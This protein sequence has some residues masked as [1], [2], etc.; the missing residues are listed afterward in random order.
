MSS[1]NHDDFYKNSIKK[2]SEETRTVRKIVSIVLLV[3]TISLVVAGY[4]G[5]SYVKNGLQPVDPNSKETKTI[6]IPIGSSVSK[7]GDILEQ[8]GII[9]NSRLFQ[10]YIKF[11]N[12]SNFQAGEYTF[13]PSMSLD[14]L[15]E[16]LKTGKI[17]REALY[18]VTIP[19]GKTVD[20]IA[21]I[22]ANKSNFT[23]DEFL[24]K[25]N[26]EEY[27]QHLIETYPD[28]LTEDILH[29]DIRAPLEG[30]LFASTYDF[31]EENPSIE[32]VIK[33]MLDKTQVVISPYL[34]K[35]EESEFTVHELVTMASLVEMEAKTL[36]DR[37]LISSVFQNRLSEGMM[38][39]TDPT[40]LYALGEHKDRV[41]YVDLEVD[42]PYNTYQNYGLPIGPI[43][44]F[45]EDSLIASLE[46]EQS[47]YFYFVAAPDGKIHYAETYEEH[48]RLVN[49]YL[50]NNES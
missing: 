15:I 40:V 19:E 46:P 13:S 2:R 3:L 25:V 27:I 8:E 38:L 33:K 44:N 7:I 23:K 30:Y 35:M 29:P 32:T 49:Q 10:L 48:Q 34:G 6:E 42:S 36:E 18:K 28:I 12:E 47:N 1:S 37:M 11:N 43:A 16:S 24:E 45:S 31:Y 26:D 41:L 9:N 21:E 14:Q 50:R 39:Q 22:M 5:Y 20:Q 4:S 17:I